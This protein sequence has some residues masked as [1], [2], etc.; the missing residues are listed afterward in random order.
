M[1]CETSWNSSLPKFHV[2]LSWRR[3]LD[4]G[5]GRRLRDM[6]HGS[7][8]AAEA[9]PR[10]PA[11][12][13]FLFTRM[14]EEGTKIEDDELERGI[15]MWLGSVV[16][17]FCS[18]RW[19]CRILSLQSRSITPH[20]PGAGDH[21]HGPDHW[22]CTRQRVVPDFDTSGTQ[23]FVYFADVKEFRFYYRLFYPPCTLPWFLYRRCVQS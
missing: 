9:S 5:Q 4:M 12:V 19:G 15:R 7:R 16:C 20:C 10:I 8:R 13:W 6:C 23:Y 22:I 1:L 3:R 18:G 11:F 14:R 2:E 21:N 17:I